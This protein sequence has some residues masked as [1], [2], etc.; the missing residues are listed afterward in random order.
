MVRQ[1]QISFHFTKEYQL[2]LLCRDERVSQLVSVSRAEMDT[3][4]VAPVTMRT[5]SFFQ[6]C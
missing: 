6:A 4:L 2:V 5:D 3:D 1:T